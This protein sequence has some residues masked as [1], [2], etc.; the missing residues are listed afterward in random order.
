MLADEP[1]RAAGDLRAATTRVVAGTV[2]DFDDEVG[3]GVVEAA[4]GRFGFHC[5]EIADGTRHV[6]RGAG[7]RFRLVPGRGGRLEARDLRPA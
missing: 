5:A 7:V 4:E 1:A 2:A 6:E 3:L